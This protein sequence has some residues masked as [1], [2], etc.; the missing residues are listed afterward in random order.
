MPTSRVG[1]WR[2]RIIPEMVAS[3]PLEIDRQRGNGKY[4]PGGFTLIELLVTLSIAA[5]LIGIT[6]PKISVLFPDTEATTVMRFRH[7]LMKARWV[8][9]RDQVPVRVTFDFKDQRLILSEV[10][11]GKR[12]DLLTLFLPP[13]VRMMGGWNVEPG[14]DTA[15]SILFYPDG[16]GEGFGI[17]LEKGTTRLTAVGY[18]YRPGVELLSG[19]R[20]NPRNG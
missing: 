15:F 17:Y 19:W 13:N 5:I 8:A 3:R 11:K 6:A 10:R 4:P 16:R 18:P 14:K 12:K 9:A 7:I 1:I 2:R 20:E